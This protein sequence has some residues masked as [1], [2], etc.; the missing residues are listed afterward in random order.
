MSVFLFKD[1]VFSLFV[2]DKGGELVLCDMCIWLSVLCALCIHDICVSMLY[3]SMCSVNV[4][5]ALL[6]NW[7]CSENSNLK[8]LHVMCCATL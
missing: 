6:A 4:L 8:I 1:Y 5:L 7:L 2:N 3:V